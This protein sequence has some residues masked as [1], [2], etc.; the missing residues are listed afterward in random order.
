MTVHL[1]EARNVAK[2]AKMSLKLKTLLLQLHKKHKINHRNCNDKFLIYLLTCKKCF[3][4]YVGETIEILRK[5]W[6]HHK[7]NTRAFS[8]TDL[9]G[10]GGCAQEA[11]TP[12][13]F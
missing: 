10:G 2:Y 3:K 12:P 9:G 7:N 13:K 1:N 11:H 8:A 4:G 6:D 5:R